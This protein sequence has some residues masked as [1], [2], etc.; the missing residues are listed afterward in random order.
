MRA[1]PLVLAAWL[2]APARG[3]LAPRSRAEDY[4]AHARAG[5]L[6]IAAE[7]D[8]RT[9]SKGR[10]WF[11]LRDA[12]V[13]EAAVFGPDG[14][15]AQVSPGQFSLRINGK[16]PALLPLPPG[17]VISQEKWG[18]TPSLTVE[19]QGGRVVFG[20][21]EAA[22]RFPGDPRGPRSDPR[23]KPPK[24]DRRREDVGPALSPAEFLQQAALPSG[25]RALPVAGYLYF[26]YR[27]K[28][29][30]I[31]KLELFYQGPEGGATIR[32]R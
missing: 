19:A 1:A 26:P 20:G 8:F 12:I 3:E 5:R 2:A 10:D 7:F 13:V 29:R 30:K 25:K 31:K 27:G 11:F 24:E 16:G 28:I 18:Q 15:A 6:E 17:V 22:P 14:E 4:P 9:V 32:L 21:P 23:P